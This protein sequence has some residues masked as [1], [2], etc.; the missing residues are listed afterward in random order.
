MIDYYKI[1]G[2]LRNANKFEIKAAFRNLAMKYHP[3]K[4]NSVDAHE[5]F[6]QITEAYEVLID[7]KK[8]EEYNYFFDKFTILK[9]LTVYEE[10]YFSHES[11]NWQKHGKE[12]AS[13]YSNMNL[14]FFLR[15]ILNEAVFHGGYIARIGCLTYFFIITGAVSILMIPWLL[16]DSVFDKESEGFII[17]FLIGLGI[18]LIYTGVNG[19]KAE[20]ENYKDNFKSRKK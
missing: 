18:W 8:R 17:L 2:I 20:I 6:I 15:N 13:E 1:L 19:V 4:N 10:P 3:D 9:E 16:S 5:K 7:D 11:K 14:E 12:K